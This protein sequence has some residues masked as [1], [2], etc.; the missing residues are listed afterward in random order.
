MKFESYWLDT[1]PAFDGGAEGSLE[2]RADVA[3]VGGGFTGLSAASSLA[4]LGASVV[5]LEGDRIVGEG[6]G[7]NGG[8]CNTG[9]VQDYAELVKSLGKERA[10]DCYRTFSAAVDTVEQLVTDENI[11]CDF[12][13]CGKIK[14]AAKPGHYEKLVRTHEAIGT[15]LDPNAVLV[16]P[17][18]IGDEVGSDAFYGGL[19][20]STSA[21]LHPGKLGFGLADLA[22]RH[23]AKIYESAVVTRMKRQAN[24]DYRLSTDRGNL[25]ATQLLLATGCTAKGPFSWFRRRIVPVGSFIIVTEPLDP[26]LLDRLLPNRR[27][28]VTSKNLSN[29]YRVTPDNRLLFGGRARFSTS[30]RSSDEKCGHILRAML[31][32]Y[33]PELK[34]VG[35][36]YCWG[37]LVDMTKDRLPRAGERRGL[38][39]SLGY[40][41]HGVQMSVHMGQVMADVMNGRQDANPWRDLSWPA[42]PGHIGP[43]WFL[44]AVGAYYRLMDVL[45]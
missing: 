14:L 20:Q 23:G 37:G 29:Y 44:P 35:V 41:G 18:Q 12:R 8:Q 15:D 36:D 3:I 45:H 4:K 10:S 6:S 24:G 27:C 39:Y 16:T 5:V 30:N 34:D 13:R 19:L 25:D 32:R 31:A 7:R 21:Q 1:L 43:P 22:V 2:G 11:D 40:S 26:A 28:Y 42:I 33:F 17:D 38:F 9:V